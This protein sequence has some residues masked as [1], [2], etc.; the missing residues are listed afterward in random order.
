MRCAIEWS[1][2]IEIWKTSANS[3]RA[4]SGREPVLRCCQGFAGVVADAGG[5]PGDSR[6]VVL[7]GVVLAS[8][9]RPI[10]GAESGAKTV[11]LNITLPHEQYPNP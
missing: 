8:W 1:P 4:D 11:G 2:K 7:T 10:G 5:G 9:K 6:L 3:R